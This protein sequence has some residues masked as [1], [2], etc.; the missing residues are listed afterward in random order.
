MHRSFLAAVALWLSTAPASAKELAHTVRTPAAGPPARARAPAPPPRT[1]PPPKRSVWLGL[2]YQYLFTDALAPASRHGVGFWASYEFHVS[3]R[4][5]VGL[6][7]AYRGYPGEGG[8]HQIGYGVTLRHLFSNDWARGRKV[9]PFIDYGLLQQQT[10]APGH[11]G[12]AVSHDTRLG[13]G[14][15]FGQLGFPL[16]LAASAHLS[17][18]EFFDVET[19]WIPFVDVSLGGIFAF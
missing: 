5:L 8:A 17:R 13:G 6:P 14:A 11:S 10:F 19:E 3:P 7:L 2:S 9:Y 4:F 12:V 15:V 18:L 1:E 16:F